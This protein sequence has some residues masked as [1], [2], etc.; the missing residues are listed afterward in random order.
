M[1]RKM[2]NSFNKYVALSRIHREID[3]EA[4]IYGS[5]FKTPINTSMTRDKSSVMNFD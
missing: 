5:G 4:S 3:E 2:K 1:R